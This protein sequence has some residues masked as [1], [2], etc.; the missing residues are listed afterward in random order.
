MKYKE[1]IL[2]VMNKISLQI[3]AIE[4]LDFIFVC[5]KSFYE[6]SPWETKIASDQKIKAAIEGFLNNRTFI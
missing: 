2:N 5:V 4:D 1:I 3:A 6:E